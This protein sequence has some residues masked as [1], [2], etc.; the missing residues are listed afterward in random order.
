MERVL[1]NSP[2]KKVNT[3]GAFQGF[4]ARPSRFCGAGMGEGECQVGE[5]LAVKSTDI[6]EALKGGCHTQTGLSPIR[7]LAIEV[8]RG[9]QILLF[10][11]ET[12][13]PVGR[14]GA[15]GARPDG[16]DPVA[17]E[18]GV[19]AYLGGVCGRRQ[20][21]DCQLA[22]RL[23]KAVAKRI[24]RR[25]HAFRLFLFRQNERALLKV[26]LDSKTARRLWWRCGWSRIRLLARSSEEV[27]R[28]S[29]C[30]G[31]SVRTHEAASS[32]A[33]GIP[34][35]FRQSAQTAG[36]LRVERV[37][38]GRREQTELSLW[39]L[40]VP[41]VAPVPGAGV[42]E[43][44]GVDQL[45]SSAAGKAKGAFEFS[46]APF[47]FSYENSNDI[48]LVSKTKRRRNIRLISPTPVREGGRK[49]AFAAQLR[50][51]LI[52]MRGR[53]CPADTVRVVKKV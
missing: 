6:P 27:R 4:R 26:R 9:P 35:S 33:S 51:L 43:S 2:R 15:G 46:N 20:L 47:I 12:I 38:L 36:W 5:T 17:K 32:M 25:L 45:L 24:D 44:L 42:H 3:A 50:H 53:H 18:V 16:D 28:A 1:S 7:R 13:E 40:W 22:D 8:Q 29:V 30:S 34:S 52:L 21:L 10:A 11:L 49:R 23:Q 31:V 41:V 39:A 48:S 14:L 19:S 37:K